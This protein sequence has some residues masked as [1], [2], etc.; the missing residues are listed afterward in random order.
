MSAKIK[1][2]TTAFPAANAVLRRARAERAHGDREGEEVQL[3]LL[4][5]L[6]FKALY[7]AVADYR[8]AS[9]ESSPT[10][11]AVGRYLDERE[12]AARLRPR[13]AVGMRK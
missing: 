7:H 9:G 3:A 10:Y 6:A 1:P 11:V 12:Q 4:L 8:G 13:R 5:R 2:I